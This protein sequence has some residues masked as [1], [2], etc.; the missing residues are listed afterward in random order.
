MQE[1]SNKEYY[2]FVNTISGRELGKQY[3][4]LHQKTLTYITEGYQTVAHLYDFV[5][6]DDR[7]RGLQ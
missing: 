3:L 4:T 5:E 1:F 6:E 2:F 7:L